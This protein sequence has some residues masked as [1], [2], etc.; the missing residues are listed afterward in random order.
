MPSTQFFCCLRTSNTQNRKYEAYRE[1][2][3]ILEEYGYSFSYRTLRAIDWASSSES[4]QICCK[5]DWFQF[6][7][8]LLEAYFACY[9]AIPT[10]FICLGVC[11]FLRLLCSIN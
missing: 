8:R 11:G 9:K 3:S 7:Y 5:M 4:P 10:Y 2:L 1:S 6:I